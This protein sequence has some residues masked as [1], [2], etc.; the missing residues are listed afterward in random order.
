MIRVRA[1]FQEELMHHFGSVAILVLL[2]SG[3][4]ALSVAQSADDV[5]KVETIAIKAALD[6][7]PTVHRARIVLNTMMVEHGAAPGHA[8]VDIRPTPRKAGI[9]AALG[10]SS[11][12]REETVQCRAEPAQRPKCSLVNAELFVSA[13]K[14]QFAETTATVT[15]T[16][17]EPARRGLHYETL[18]VHLTR[19]AG[20]WVVTRLQQLGIS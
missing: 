7:R 9:A 8:A 15:V 2:A 10:V 18:Q 11:R 6:A 20:G 3:W 5:A 14:P 17:E 1:I 13:S 19:T 4:P 12:A 16:I